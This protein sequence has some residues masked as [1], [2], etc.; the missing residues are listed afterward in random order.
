MKFGIHIRKL[1][2]RAFI[3]NV[4]CCHLFCHVRKASAFELRKKVEY[5]ELFQI[6]LE[7]GGQL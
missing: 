1:G 3:R 6:K 7:T 4:T 5:R 2:R